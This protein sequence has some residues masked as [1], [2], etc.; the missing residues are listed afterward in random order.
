MARSIRPV[1]KGQK[2]ALNCF[3]Q[4]TKVNG[5]VFLIFG[6]KIVWSAYLSNFHNTQAMVNLVFIGLSLLMLTVTIHAV[7]TDLW[8][9]VLKQRESWLY[10]SEVVPTLGMLIGTAVVMLSLNVIE[11]L[12]WAV[13]YWLAPETGEITNLEQATYF[14]FITFTT[15]GYGDIIIGSDWQ[16]LCGIEAMNGIFLFGWSAALLFAVVQRIWDSKSDT[17]KDLPDRHSRS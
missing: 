4:N 5:Q 11:A 10:G 1:L 13:V 9:K 6:F 15:L 12:V 17:N 3:R 16:L 7:G 8:V 14:S 2:L